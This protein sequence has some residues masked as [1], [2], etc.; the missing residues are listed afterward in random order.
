MA[1]FGGHLYRPRRSCGKVMFLHLSVSHSVHLGGVWQ[2]PHRQTPHPMATAADGTHPTGLLS[3]FLDLFFQTKEKATV[4]IM[5]QE[6]IPVGCVLS[7]AVAAGGVSQ[8]ALGRGL[9]IPACTG[10]GGGLYPS[11]HWEV[12]WV[13][14]HALGRGVYPSMHL[15]GG[16]LPKG[17]LPGG[18][19]LPNTPSPPVDRVTDACENITLPQLRCGR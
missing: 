1:A 7:T 15:E 6:C 18:G 3:Y 2:T 5:K 8:Y 16:C 13:S 14:Q 19:C 9:C 11:M 10:Q 4:N 17:C 12:G